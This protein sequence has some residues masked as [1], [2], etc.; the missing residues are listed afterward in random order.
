M[1]N[2]KKTKASKPL[3]SEN[4]SVLLA[5]LPQNILKIG[6]LVEEDKNIYISQTAYKAIHN[7]TKNKLENESGGMLM[8]YT[9]EGAGKTNIII[10]GFIEAKHS[11]ATPTTLTF[12]HETWEYVHAEADKNYPEYKIIG[13]IHTH[14]SFGIFLSEYDKFIQQN[15]FDGENQIAYVVDPIQKIEGFYFWINGKIEKSNGFYIYDKTGIPIVMEPERNEEE[16]AST[17]SVVV[18]R[19][20]WKEYLLAA[21]SLL[22][23]VVLFISISLSGKLS[24]LENDTSRIISEQKSVQTYISSLLGEISNLKLKVNDLQSSVDD[25][26]DE[27][28]NSKYNCKIIFSNYD[29]SKISESEYKF[30]AKITEPETPV[31]ASDER[32]NYVFAGWDKTPDLALDNAIYVAKYTAVERDYIITFVDIKGNIISKDIYHYGDTVVVPSYSET[33]NSEEPNNYT[34]VLKWDKTIDAVKGDSTYTAIFDKEYIEYTVRFVRDDGSLIEEKTYHYNDTITVNDPTR[35]STATHTYTF[36]AWD[37]AFAPVTENTE[38]TANF[39]E[40]PITPPDGGNGG[41]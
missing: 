27:Y 16:R 13:W 8:G 41:E 1:A 38:Y 19:N 24:D 39:E 14:P 7:F 17:A 3:E 4:K 33:K 30:G 9:L 36:T 11:E 18:P 32:Y 22:L 21:T 6:G 28:E 10:D 35:D 20:N 2:K 29:G 23:V 31:K 12:T 26:E 25:V 5:S 40:T 15:F 37:R 34:Y